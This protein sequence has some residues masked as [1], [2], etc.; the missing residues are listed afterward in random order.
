MEFNLIDTAYNDDILTYGSKNMMNLKLNMPENTFPI[1]MI[2]WVS[3]E[4]FNLNLQKGY[5]YLLPIFTAGKYSIETEKYKYCFYV[6]LSFF[7]YFFSGTVLF[8]SAFS[9]YNFSKYFCRYSFDF[10]FIFSLY[11]CLVTKR[12]SSIEKLSLL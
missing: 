9:W 7:P 5:D 1:S 12:A 10:I 4:G 6:I 11:S 2:P 3:F 8:I